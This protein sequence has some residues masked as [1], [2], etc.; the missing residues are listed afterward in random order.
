MTVHAPF[1]F[2]SRE[3]T[4]P[5]VEV[6]YEGPGPQRRLTIAFRIVLALPHLVYV[7]LV[8]IAA[9][10]AIVAGWFAALL[11]GRL[12]AGVADFL[13]RV[14]QYVA[15][16]NAYA[17]LLLTDRY[18]P[19]DLGRDDYAV[20]VD[21]PGCVRLNRAAVLFRIVL[22]IPATIVVQLIG[23]GLF[24]VA[25]VA[26]LLALMMGRLPI[27]LFEAFAAVLRYQTRFYAYAALLTSEYPRGL[28]GDGVRVTH[29]PYPQPDAEPHTAPYAPPFAP[30]GTIDLP[31]PPPPPA[32]AGSA[33]RI[34]TL[35]LSRAAKVILGVI[36]GLGAVFVIAGNVA[37]VVLGDSETSER[38]QESYLVLS[39]DSQRY[40]LETQRCAVSGGIGCLQEANLQFAGAVRRFQTELRALEFTDVAID[41]AEQLDR[42]ATD[43]MLVLE[44]MA[45]TDEPGQYNELLAEF[46]S[47]ANAF[48]ADFQ[49]LL[50]EVE[51]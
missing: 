42:G 4:T 12:P 30:Q 34:T 3:W 10:V 14:V 5:E 18:P 31:P 17:Y 7:A 50:D 15:R 39:E 11:L 21:I 35:L 33:P 22:L 43:L 25:L 32:M 36:L 13:A 44:R 48:D 23:N 45:S 51:F 37:A 19:F 41:E 29:P 47:L 9:L 38:L 16:V 2:A 20:S 24:V 40:G 28:F 26:W 1:G 27:P 46:Q 49:E 8:S 6:S